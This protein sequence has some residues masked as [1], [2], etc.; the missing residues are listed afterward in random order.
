[1][2]KDKI[3]ALRKAK[4][5]TQEQMSEYCGMSFAGYKGYEAGRSEPTMT[6]LIKI[7]NT[8]EVSL[9]ELCGF[10][11]QTN[12]S[13]ALQLRMRKISELNEDEQRAIDIVLQGILLKHQADKTRLEF[14]H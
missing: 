10:E 2:S 8:L 14:Q 7:A 12:S 9:D 3:K 4:G 1:M 11:M 13:H 6:N 5:L